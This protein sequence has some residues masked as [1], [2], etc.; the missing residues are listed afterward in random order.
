MRL[1]TR[2]FL[3][4]VFSEGM[5]FKEFTTA[6][7]SRGRSFVRRY[8]EISV[9]A[10]LAEALRSRIAAVG[11][12]RVLVSAEAWC[13]DAAE[14]VPTIVR[15]METAPEDVRLRLFARSEHPELDSLLHGLGVTRIPAVLLCDGDFRVLGTWQERPVPA[16]KV[17]DLIKQGRESG[18][19]TRELAARLQEGYGSDRFRHAAMEEIISA[20][21]SGGL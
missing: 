5:S 12:L 13:P 9:P 3:Q 4:N 15:L 8:D 2:E 14:N 7:G 1:S 11:E 17:V 16:H 19:D 21:G 18:E 20:V 6:A 10:E